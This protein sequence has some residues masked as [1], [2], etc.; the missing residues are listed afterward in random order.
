MN[1]NIMSEA[2]LHV[3]KLC[4]TSRRKKL[5]F[6]F[7]PRLAHFQRVSVAEQTGFSLTLP[8]GYKTFFMLNSAELEIYPAHKC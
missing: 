6:G 8:R 5:S 4:F 3:A 7:S 1:A 2:L